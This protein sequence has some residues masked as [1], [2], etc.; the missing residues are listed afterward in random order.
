MQTQRLRLLRSTDAICLMLALVGSFQIAVRPALALDGGTLRVLPDNG[1][2]AFEVITSGDDPTGDGFA[3]A[4]PPTFDGMGAWIADSN[5]LRV[6][7]N[8]EIGDA[9][10]SEVN[11]DIS[12]LETALSQMISAGSTGGGRFVVSA[13]QAYDRWSDDGGATWTNTSNTS[14]TSFNRFC[15]G[16]SYPPNT[17]GPDRGFV[18][19]TYITGEEFGS[20]RL[21]AID[22]LN[23][24]LYLLSGTAGSA[25]GGTGGIPFDS[26][27]NAALL[28]TG[29]TSHIALLLSPDGGSQTLQL[30]IGEKGKDASGAAASSYLA[31]NGLAY[32][33][34]YYLN[35]A[36]PTVGNTNSGNFDTSLAGGLTSGKLEDVDTSPSN[37]T[38]TVLGDQTSG[39]FSFDFNLVFS[40]AFD[41]AASDFSVT[42]ISDTSGG[43]NSLN[44]PDNVDW[45]NT[46]TLGPTFYPDGLI[47]VNEDNSSG[48]IW[49]IEPDGSNPIRIASTTV[50]AE[51]TGILDISELL[52]YV[53][54][55]IVLTNNQGSPSSMSI[56]I[57]PDAALLPPAAVPSMRLIGFGILGVALVATSVTQARMK[58]RS[59]HRRAQQDSGR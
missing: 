36:Y 17:F 15:S 42:K 35:A 53:P 45:T 23:R 7:V 24:D 21:F 22:S 4:M 58:R 52:E 10:I 44:A 28:D 26:W 31:R 55:S 11:L 29:E 6:Q 33:S 38:Q 16:Q 19:E 48:E 47:F 2:I 20:D 41:D 49:Q 8:H 32:G 9:A 56:L 59:R 46:T 1:W 5:T 37:P 50:S 40:P 39:V 3:Y 14:N 13:R 25:A 57:H 18:D 27:E 30:Y 54:G 12:A 43:I 34:W 51:S